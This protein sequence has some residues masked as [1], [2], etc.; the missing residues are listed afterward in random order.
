MS[1]D[2]AAPGGSAQCDPQQSHHPVHHPLHLR[3]AAHHGHS[4]CNHRPVR[5]FWSP[6]TQSAVSCLAS[7]AFQQ[8]STWPPGP[9][10][11]APPPRA[12]LSFS[13]GLCLAFV[14]TQLASMSHLQHL[15]AMFLLHLSEMCSDLLHSPARELCIAKTGALVACFGAGCTPQRLLYTAPRVHTQSPP[16]PIGVGR[17]LFQGAAE[18]AGAADSR[19]A[20]H[21]GARNS[22]S[23]YTTR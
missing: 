6:L 10:L 5:S 14:C 13:Q 17:S 1:I 4:L 21:C 3:R 12:C 16:E 20:P 9:S 11:L 2:T 22:T 7:G 8:S 19:G 15:P 18:E 23:Y